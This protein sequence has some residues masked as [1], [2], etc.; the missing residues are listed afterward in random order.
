VFAFMALVLIANS[1]LLRAT[2]AIRGRRGALTNKVNL[3]DLLILTAVGAVTSIIV[4]VG[5]TFLTLSAASLLGLYGVLVWL[6]AILFVQYRIEINRQTIAWFFT[7]ANGLGKGIP[8]LLALFKRYPIT[9]LIPLVWLG[10][11]WAAYS[12]GNIQHLGALY[13]IAKFALCS[14]MLSV[15]CVYFP[16]GN[17]Y[18]V[19]ATLLCMLSLL[20]V[21]VPAITGS[22]SQT[23]ILFAAVA[24]ILVLALLLLLTLLRKLFNHQHEFLTSP[25]LLNNILAVDNFVADDGVILNTEHEDFVK[26]AA[27]SQSKSE[28][29]G[30]CAGAN[31]ILITVESLG[32]YISPY[33]TDGARSRLSEKLASKSWFSK[34][35]FCLCPNT[36]VSTN[37]IY[38]GAYSNN[39]YNMLDSLFPGQEPKHI[40]AL[41]QEGYKTLFLD[42]ANINLFDYKKLLKRIGFDRVWGT[43]DIPEHGLKA[44]Y[45]LWNMVDVIAK[46]V[47]DSP[48]YLH[49]INDQTHM[50]YEVVDKQRFSNH[51]GASQKSSYLNALEEVDYILDVFLQKLAEKIDLSNTILVFTGDHG[52]SFGEFG[53]SFH[54]N[55]VIMPQMQVPFMLSHPKLEAKNLEHSCHFDLFP[56]FFDLLG[57]EYEHSSI[58][59]TLGL[60]DRD[61]V[62]FVHSATLKGNSPANFGLIQDGV[63]C[64][65]DRLFNQVAVLNAKQS[66]VSI[67]KQDEKYIKAMLHRMLKHRGVLV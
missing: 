49:L 19:A 59:Q 51:K 38:T 53:Y 17:V 23:L 16:R 18:A 48:F 26:P 47:A 64:W 9:A 33:I 50:P 13:N 54:S 8:H 6:D 11:V 44:D 52:E 24:F 30:T 22:V 15:L 1:A 27:K 45:R 29:F 67:S 3:D 14:T 65:V 42:S 60:D 34:Q 43:E 32:A 36:T 2:K 10:G 61:F 28:Y 63:L 37:Q 7:G 21:S 39:P 46:E 40:K 5:N 55:S 12:L 31:V 25:T 58:G 66:K 20:S 57:I 62:Y 35:H 56:T 41:K 4:F